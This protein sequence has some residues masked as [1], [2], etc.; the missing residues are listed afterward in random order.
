MKSLSGM[1]V[2]VTGADGFIPSYV[3]E[4]LV[5]DGAEVVALVRRNSSNI[6]KNIDH[7]KKDL[8]IVWG[9][10]QDLSSMI[11]LTKGI[12]I[13]YHLAA[14]SHVA[15]SIINPV[16]SFQIQTDGT[17]NLLEA[18]RFNNVGRFIHAGSAEEYGVTKDELIREDFPLI[19]RSPYAA[20]KVAADRLM[21]SYWCSYGT[22]VVMSR[23][24]G[25]YG[26]RQSAEKAIPKFILQALHGE[27]ITI[28]GDGSQTRDF[29]FGSDAGKAYA[30][31]GVADNII[32]KVINI[33]TGIRYP[34][35]KIAEDILRM[36]NIKVPVKKDMNLK[37]GEAS[38]L[39]ADPTLLQKTL[40][41]KPAVKWEEG[42][43]KTIAHY[44]QHKDLYSRSIGRV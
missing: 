11:Y 37:P 30:E 29:M 21:Y 16:E 12:D 33:G 26:P 43:E 3:C 4:K 22:P 23:F 6:L 20:G 25:I 42:L 32:G 40:Q 14:N 15:Y 17:I 24:F 10:I 9:D 8:K 28:Y 39:V 27:T 1:K 2:L 36:L 31:L 18:A 19:P 38:H 5:N 35:L 34:I 13:I 41:W 7:L 44:V